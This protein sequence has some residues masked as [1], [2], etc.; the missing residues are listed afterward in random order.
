MSRPYIIGSGFFDRGRDGGADRLYKIWWKNKIKYAKPFKIHIIAQAGHFPSRTTQRD[1]PADWLF[2]DGDLGHIHDINSGRK[3][4]DWCAYTVALATLCHIAY[5][6]ECDL[7]F[8][9][10]DCLAFGPWP[11]KI[12]DE[13]GDAKVCYGTGKL[14]PCFQSLMLIKHDYLPTFASTYMPRGSERD[15]ANEGEVRMHRLAQEFP[16]DYKAFSFGYDRDR[17]FNVQDPVWYAQQISQEELTTI[18]EAGLLD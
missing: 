9:E 16:Q 17:P 10:Q 8:C 15:K 2:I 4:Y 5:M 11:E 12:Y 7:M 13:C 18:K 3:P 14:M 1:Y 6:E